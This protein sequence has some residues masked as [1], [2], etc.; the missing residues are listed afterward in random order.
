MDVSSYS[1]VVSR[2]GQVVARV[3][4]EEDGCGQGLCNGNRLE[5]SKVG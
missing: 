3:Q 5:W 2:S 1:G 4:V